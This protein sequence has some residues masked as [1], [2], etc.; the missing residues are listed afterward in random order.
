MVVLSAITQCALTGLCSK[1]L[2]QI[3]LGRGSSTFSP[4]IASS[5]QEEEDLARKTTSKI[6]TTTQ[7]WTGERTLAQTITGQLPS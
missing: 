7:S 6:V 1:I 3:A 5:S 4:S 2:L